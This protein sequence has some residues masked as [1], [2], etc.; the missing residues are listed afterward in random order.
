M[1]VAPEAL[2]S[3][4]VNHCKVGITRRGLLIVV[5]NPVFLDVA[6]IVDTASLPARQDNVSSPIRVCGKQEYQVGAL[7]VWNHHKLPPFSQLSQRILP[8]R[9]GTRFVLEVDR[10]WPRGC[11]AIELVFELEQ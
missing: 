3:L 8:Y 10:P 6:L 11:G 5:R 1:A 9:S 4:R 2:S 7:R